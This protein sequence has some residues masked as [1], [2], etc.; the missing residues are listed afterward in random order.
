MRDKRQL[1]LGIMGL[2]MGLMIIIQVKSVPETVYSKNE[3]DGRK[4]VI[5]TLL[6]EQA[7]LKNQIITLRKQIES[8]Q[9]ELKKYIA[10]DD[11]LNQIEELKMMVGLTEVIG[12][13]VE[14]IL[15]DSP[16]VNRNQL[17]IDNQSIVHAADLRDILNLLRFSGAK[18]IAVNEQRVVVTSPVSCVGNSILV[19]NLHL[20]PP[21][22]IKA[23][24][25]PVVILNNLNSEGNLADFKKRVRDQGVIFKFAKKSKIF[26]SVFNSDLSVQYLN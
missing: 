25:D 20:L 7:V 12:E 21:L 1:F 13:G 4:Y 3:L 19:N 9:D 5:E 17:N 26:I 16:L 14:I 10:N 2:L 22:S 18:A 11:Q 6:N 23:I 24:G 8:K 15:E